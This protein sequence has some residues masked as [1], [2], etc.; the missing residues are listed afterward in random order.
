VEAAD[1]VGRYEAMRKLAVDNGP[2][3]TGWGLALFVSRGLVAWMRAWPNRSA[4]GAEPAVPSESQALAPGPIDSQAA[5]LPPACYQQLAAV[6]AS[7]V[8]VGLLYDAQQRVILD[9]D[10]QVQQLLKTFFDVFQRTR[11]AMGTVKYFNRHGLLFPRRLRRGARKGEL[12]WAPLVHSRALQVLHNPRYAGAFVHGRQRACKTKEGRKSLR[13]VPQEEWQVVIP[14]AHPGYISWDQYQRNQ[15][16]L[17]EYAQAHGADRR[18]SPPGE[19]PALL[20]G[21]VICG[22]CGQRMSVRYYSR[23]RHRH[24]QYVF[25][26]MA[27]STLVVS[28][29]ALRAAASTNGSGSCF[30]SHSRQ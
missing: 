21:L 18:K 24:P 16:Q 13:K 8:P 7:P 1:W 28:V 20:Q 4:N 30:C 27:S 12:I 11:T 14:D 29:R 26:G 15:Q 23:G 17:R 6:L 9:P 25:N 19:G 3:R 22:V 10:R 2:S 5:S